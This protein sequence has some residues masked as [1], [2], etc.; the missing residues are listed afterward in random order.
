M[1]NKFEGL[2]KELIKAKVKAAE[3]STGTK[4]NVKDE[5]FIAK[6][7]EYTRDAIV[8]FLSR[9]KFR[10][11]S[12]K[13]PISVEQFSIPEQLVDIGVETLLGEYAPVLD[14]LK[15][16]GEPLGLASTID[17]LEGKIAV[18]ITNTLKSNPAKTKAINIRKDDGGLNANGYTFIG[19]DPETQEQFIDEDNPRGNTTVEFFEDDNKG[20]L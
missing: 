2:K 8:N 7:A 6:N 20:I 17:S 12:F 3:E 4:L 9:A 10:V 19:E 16:I 5:D 18:A 15:K 14:A 13:A 1:S 11:T